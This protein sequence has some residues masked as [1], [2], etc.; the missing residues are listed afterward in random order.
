[1]GVFR[2]LN[3]G[4]IIGGVNDSRRLVEFN[5]DGRRAVLEVTSNVDFN[6]QNPNNPLRGFTCPTGSTL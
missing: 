3:Q 5:F 4:R 2:L 1:M 6:L